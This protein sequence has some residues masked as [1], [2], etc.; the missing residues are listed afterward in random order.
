MS[1]LL[2]QASTTS[3]GSKGPAWTP[4]SASLEW[5]IEA[6]YPEGE[7]HFVLKC[8]LVPPG[9]TRLQVAAAAADDVTAAATIIMRVG[10]TLWPT[11]SST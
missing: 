10:G 6:I 9:V 8:S 11:S 5:T 3:R 2:P 7:Q 1:V 4:R